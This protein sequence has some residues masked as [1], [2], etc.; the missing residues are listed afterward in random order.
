MFVGWFNCKVVSDSFATPRTVA[1]RLLCL[2]DSPGQKTGVASQ[3]LL[4]GNLPDPGTEPESPALQAVS[5]IAGR[6]FTAET[7]TKSTIP[8]YNRQI[9]L[10]EKDRPHSLRSPLCTVVDFLHFS[11]LVPHLSA[12]GNIS[13][14]LRWGYSG[15]H[16][17][18]PA[19]WQGYDQDGPV[20]FSCPQWL[21]QLI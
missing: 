1:S 19:P 5:C 17:A 11:C 20:T 12:R 16:R 10:D 8:I 6:F 14:P 18:Q 21:V 7:P 13:C 15:H 3:S 4:K 9:F 2:W